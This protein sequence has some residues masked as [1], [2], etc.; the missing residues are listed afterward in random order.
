MPQ[1]GGAGESGSLRL[2]ADGSAERATVPGMSAPPPYAEQVASNMLRRF[3][4]SAI[5]QLHL[6]AAAAH[7]SGKKLAAASMIEIADA[8][9]RLWLRKRADDLGQTEGPAADT[10]SRRE[11]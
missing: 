5:W 11:T 1:P 8:A 6:S 9:E 4:F 10:G 2:Q 7:R 3:G